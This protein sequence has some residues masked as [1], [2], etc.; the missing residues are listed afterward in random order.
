VSQVHALFLLFNNKVVG[1]LRRQKNSMEDK[2]IFAQAQ[3]IVRWHY[4]WLVLRDYL[5]KIVGE[6]MAR[7]VLNWDE[8]AFPRLRFFRPKSDQAY[9]PD[10]FS[11]AA[12]RFGH[13]MVR[14][15]Y[16]LSHATQRGTDSRF[17]RIPIFSYFF[18]GEEGKFEASSAEQ[19][20]PLNLDGLQPLPDNWGIDWDFFFRDTSALHRDDGGPKVPQPT[21]RIDTQIVDPLSML[22]HFTD[23]RSLAYRNLLREWRLKLP[24]GESVAEA[25][26]KAIP[27]IKIVDRDELWK[28]RTERRKEF[29]HGAPL[30]FYILREAEL[31]KHK[32]HKTDILCGHHLGSV[33]GRIVA[34]VLV[35]LAY[36]DR[37]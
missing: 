35:G 8:P 36:Y 24:S 7:E 33:G 6:P 21:Y 2:D 12:F 27:G 23:I 19:K 37:K 17:H 26:R 16:A 14:P 5:P 34:E 28:G 30:W 22:P 1:R 31:E 32:D 3:Q 9:M 25:I 29:E 4:Q 11:A 10:D 18:P 20:Q 13:S 15:R